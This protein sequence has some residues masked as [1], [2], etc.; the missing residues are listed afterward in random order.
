MPMLLTQTLY[1]DVYQN[2][3]DVVLRQMIDVI[4]GESVYRGTATSYEN[5]KARVKRSEKEVNVL[6][7]AETYMEPISRYAIIFLNEEAD[8]NWNCGKDLAVM[9]GFNRD[10]GIPGVNALSF[11]FSRA[12]TPEFPVRINITSKTKMEYVTVCRQVDEEKYQ[13]IPIEYVSEL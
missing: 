9:Y 7:Y 1:L 4:N 8:I 13:V 12:T 10:V 6:I 11:N 3:F 2:G 5:I